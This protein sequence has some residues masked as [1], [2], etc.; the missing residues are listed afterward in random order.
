MIMR[1][2][3]F[4]DRLQTQNFMVGGLTGASPPKFV[5]FDEIIKAAN[6]MTNMALAHEIALDKNFKLETL[7]PPNDSLQ[8][9]VKETMHNIFWQ[10]LAQ[11]LAE[12]PPNYNQ[13][14]TLL[15]EIKE[16]IYINLLK[17]KFLVLTQ[18]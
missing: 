7:E 3:L 10:L 9:R 14:L 18:H 6:G 15:A 1:H 4:Y 5:S 11:E 16:V 17:I 2:Y 13:A 8:K 12:D